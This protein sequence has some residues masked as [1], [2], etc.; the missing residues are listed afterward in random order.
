M[1]SFIRP[2]VRAL[3]PLS[4]RQ[5]LWKYTQFG[6][7]LKQWRYEH[8]YRGEV[9]ERDGLRFR[10]HPHEQV[11]RHIYVEH[12]YGK[13]VVEI[14]L[15]AAPHFRS[16]VDCGANIGAVSVPFTRSSNLSTL[17]IEP[18][19][20]NAALLRENIAMNGLTDRITVVQAALGEERGRQSIFLSQNNLGDNRMWNGEERRDT[21]EEVE[22][23]LLDDLL[24]KYPSLKPP[25]LIKIDVQGYEYKVFSG[26]R[27]L[28]SQPCCILAEFWPKGL[29]GAGCR[30]ADYAALLRAARLDAYEIISAQSA[31]RPVD[32]FEKL[33][34]RF[35]GDGYCDL[36]LTNRKLD[37]IGLAG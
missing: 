21:T 6:Q 12:N 7:L 9:I 5:H 29:A 10:L 33:A 24:D 3:I 27:R 4:V 23:L 2:V 28:M 35:P 26:A 13:A 31:L 17:A 32:S 8:T 36:I 11:S 1:G 15:R 20:I 34:A 16:F 22:V 30:L 25:F 37:Q 14:L 19:G 18:V